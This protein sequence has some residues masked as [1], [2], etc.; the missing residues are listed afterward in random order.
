MRRESRRARVSHRVPGSRFATCGSVRTIRRRYVVV[1]PRL[2]ADPPSSSRQ[3][4][5]I[6]RANAPAASKLQ[7]CPAAAAVHWLPAA[8]AWR[9]PALPP[10]AVDELPEVPA[11]PAALRRLRRSHLRDGP[12]PPRGAPEGRSGTSDNKDGTGCFRLSS[13]F[14][15]ARASAQRRASPTCGLLRRARVLAP[16]ACL[17]YRDER[18]RSVASPPGVEQLPSLARRWLPAASV[19][20]AWAPSAGYR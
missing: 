17:A 14:Q 18:P 2:S 11:L 13:R 19:P 8:P 3:C 12:V 4:A 5:A 1:R 10:L 6:L 16:L 15:H 20:R 7:R 9:G